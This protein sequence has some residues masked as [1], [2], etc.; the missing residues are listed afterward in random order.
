MLLQKIRD[1]QYKLAEMSFSSYLICYFANKFAYFKNLNISG[2]TVKEIVENSKR[3]LASHKEYL[4]IF[5]MA[6]KENMRI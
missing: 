4:L 1:F 6:T 3:H 2:N 5:K